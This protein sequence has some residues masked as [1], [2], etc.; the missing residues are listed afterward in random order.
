MTGPTGAVA[1]AVVRLDDH[2][3]S[4]LVVA[5]VTLLLA[6]AGLVAGTEDAATGVV[7]RDE[8]A[9]FDLG[10]VESVPTSVEGTARHG[11]D[12]RYLR[13]HRSSVEGAFR[14]RLADGPPSTVTLRVEL[15]AEGRRGGSTIWRHRATVSTREPAE[16]TPGETLAVP[17]TVDAADLVAHRERLAADLGGDVDLTLEGVATRV[18]DR[19]DRRTLDDVAALDV[20]GTV[21]AVSA[22]G[23]STVRVAPDPDPP[24]VWPWVALAAGMGVA[25]VTLG[26]R[27]SGVLP[28]APSRRRRL[29]RRAFRW[30]H[31]RHLVETTTPLGVDDAVRVEDPRALVRLARRTHRPL[32]VGPEGRLLL[33]V[34]ATTLLAD[35]ADGG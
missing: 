23:G 1:W 22:G 17:V 20:D 18:D 29:A 26:G 34:E 2:W 30:R 19:G 5:I 15:V 16:V 12:G 25:G 8:V 13:A 3:R 31:R 21:L 33:T 7:A 11:F 6:G 32:L 35:P 9:G 28:L 10:S 27:V 4:L 14:Y 24:P